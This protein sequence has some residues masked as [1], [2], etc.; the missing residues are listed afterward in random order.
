MRYLYLNLLKEEV[1]EDTSVWGNAGQNSWGLGLELRAVQGT[2]VSGEEVQ[3]GWRTCIIGKEEFQRAHLRG[4]RK[5]GRVR[6]YGSH[7]LPVIDCSE[8]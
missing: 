3:W 6:Y 2:P 8:L 7:L 1:E 4:T 5:C